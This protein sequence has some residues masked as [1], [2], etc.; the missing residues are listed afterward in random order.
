M[1]ETIRKYLN[2]NYPE[3]NLSFIYGE[4]NLRFEL[5][6]RELKNGTIERVNQVVYRAAEIYKETIGYNEVIIAI[7]EYENDSFDKENKTYLSELI[8]VEILSKIKGPFEQTYYDVDEIGNKIEHSFEDKLYCDLYIG[9]IILN[10]EAI[11]KILRG[12]ANLEMG[13][14][15]SIPQDV[16]FYSIFNEIGFRIYDDRG[17]DVWSNDKEK[18]RSIYKNLNE[19]IL[20]YDRPEIDNYFN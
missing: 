1:K 10:K 3:L 8:P 9:K 18:L 11:K 20:D 7:V 2:E 14:E 4:Y 5:G 6:G 16:Y 12:K 19:W 15:P 17:C 13:F